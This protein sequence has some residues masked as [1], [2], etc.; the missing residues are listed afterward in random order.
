MSRISFV[1]D[2]QGCSL[3]CMQWKEKAGDCARRDADSCPMKLLGEE[4][5]CDST[6]VGH[7][8]KHVIHGSRYEKSAFANAVRGKSGAAD[9]PDSIRNESDDVV[10]NYE[11]LSVEAARDPA[12]IVISGSCGNISLICN[13]K[14]NL[15]GLTSIL[16]F[17][18]TSYRCSG[19]RAY[20]DSMQKSW[21]IVSS[22][23]NYSS[24]DLYALYLLVH[25]RYYQNM[26]V[27]RH[28]S[29]V[30]LH[31]RIGNKEEE[32]SEIF[33]VSPVERALA[34]AQLLC[35][36]SSVKT[37]LPLG[38]VS[39]YYIE[40]YLYT[41]EDFA[42]DAIE[43]GHEAKDRK[44]VSM[45]YGKVCA[46]WFLLKYIKDIANG[47]IENV[48]YY[49]EHAFLWS[50][51]LISALREKGNLKGML[52]TF[53]EGKRKGFDSHY[54]R[55]SIRRIRQFIREN[56]QEDDREGSVADYA[57]FSIVNELFSYFVVLFEVWKIFVGEYGENSKEVHALKD[58]VVIWDRCFRKYKY[59][60]VGPRSCGCEYH[61]YKKWSGIFN[62]L[63]SYRQKA[64][65]I[66]NFYGVL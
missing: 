25:Q 48:P 6:L 14:G 37:D 49:D 51:K 32:M 10:K 28:V 47:G 33:E 8:C 58:E 11:E 59:S 26:N 19:T 34:M 38:V 31:K 2:G 35:R 64:D 66:R 16:N 30:L 4:G 63:F 52:D 36:D 21:G 56:A 42:I 43:A 23:F 13:G 22:F 1:Y 57:V 5:K 54:M 3:D 46:V 55:G 41:I 18:N 17:G 20:Q 61:L 9:I 12:S 45:L 50:D 62:D 27:G 7:T 24:S 40:K 15:D 53:V 39:D 65:E 60:F 29:P 44:R